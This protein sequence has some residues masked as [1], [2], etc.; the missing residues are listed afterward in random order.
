MFGSRRHES[1]KGSTVAVWL[2]FEYR[3]AQGDGFKSAV[4]R[5]IYD[6]ARIASKTLSVTYYNENNLGGAPGSST[7]YDE[8]KVSW[9]P[10][11]H[12]TVGDFLLDWACKTASKAQPAKTQ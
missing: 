10:A 2:R 3:E 8:D 11:I 12:G 4:E 1:R 9:A 5:D 7:T 6:C